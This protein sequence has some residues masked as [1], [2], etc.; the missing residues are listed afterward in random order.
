MLLNDAGRR[1]LRPG[2]G[3][4]AQYQFVAEEMAARRR[5]GEAGA[6]RSSPGSAYQAGIATRMATRLSPEFPETLIDCEA[7]L[8]EADQAAAD[9]GRARPHRR[10]PE[11]PA[12]G[13]HRHASPDVGRTSWCSLA[14]EPAL[15]PR[16]RSPRATSAPFR[17][18]SS[19]ATAIR[20]AARTGLRRPLPRGPASAS[21]PTASRPASTLWPRP[22]A[23]TAARAIRRPGR[24]ALARSCRSPSPCGASIPASGC[25]KARSTFRSSAGRRRDPRGTL[26]RARHEIP[27]WRR[28]AFHFPRATAGRLGSRRP[29]QPRSPAWRGPTS[30][31]SSPTSSAG[32]PVGAARQ[33]AGTDAELRP[34]GAAKAPTSPTRSPASRS[35]ARPGPRCRPGA[36][37]PTT[38]VFRNDIPLPRDAPTLAAGLRR[39]RLPHR[40]HRQV[41]PGRR[42]AGAAGAAR[43]LRVLAGGERPRVRLRRLRHRASTTATAIERHLPGYRVDALTDAAIRYVDAHQR[44]ARSSSSS[45]SS[46]RTTRTTA[47]TTRAPTAT[48]SD[49]AAAGRRPTWRRS[50]GTTRST[51]PATTGMVKRLDEAFGRLLDALKS[52]DLIDEHDRPLHLRPRLPLQDPQRR[53]QA[54]LP[55]GFDPRADGADRAGLRRRRRRFASWSSLI[56]LPPTLLDAAGLPVPETMQGRSILPL[57]RDTGADWPEEMFVQISEIAGRPRRSAPSAGSTA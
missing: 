31:S 7:D 57:V 34:D 53:V 4:R 33:S 10:R 40:L 56:D 16:L 3:H 36:T 17:W 42:R 51:S 39:R 15:R 55:R 1:F 32:T 27:S 8:V 29:R 28:P 48:A 25:G 50:G 46:S 24:A 38:G 41:A 12:A 26:R 44:R 43:R 2:R 45:P 52:L 20:A 47:T 22:H 11:R 35:A 18:V 13:R 49:A 54:L 30:S 37:R 6:P 21:S 5:R 14:R 23:L 9:A 19:S